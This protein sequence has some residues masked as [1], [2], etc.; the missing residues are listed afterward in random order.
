MDCAELTAAAS[1]GTTAKESAAASFGV[2]FMAR[3]CASASATLAK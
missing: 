2:G 3:R 1:E